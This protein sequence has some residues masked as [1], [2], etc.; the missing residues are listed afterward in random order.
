MNRWV[1]VGAGANG[2]AAIHGTTVQDI[3]DEMF[4]FTALSTGSAFA[5]KGGI[6]VRPE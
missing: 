1:Q 2:N 4:S 6:Q 3:K 5:A